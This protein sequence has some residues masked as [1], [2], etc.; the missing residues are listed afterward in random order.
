MTRRRT[1]DDWRREVYRSTTLSDRTKVLLL[2]LADHM[3]EDRKV[4]VP[5]DRIAKALGRSERR[6][7]ERITEAH[8]AGWLSTVVRGQKGLTAVY[9][10]LFPD[11]V[12]GTDA[13]PL[14]RR[15]S[16]FSGTPTSPLNDAETRPLNG[17]K[18]A[19]SGTHGGPTNR[20][21]DLSVRGADRDEERS[22]EQVPREAVVDHRGRAT[23]DREESA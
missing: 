3:R 6:I 15:V 20:R 1:P 17:P 13:R 14:N 5:R 21:A 18:Q 2:F 11:V 22:E 7:T 19:F 12:S 9:Q 23:H 10:G 4:S 8:D 16:Q